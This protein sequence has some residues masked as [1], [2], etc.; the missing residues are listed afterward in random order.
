[1]LICGNGKIC[2]ERGDFLAIGVK[3]LVEW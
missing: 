3:I 2:V 1:M